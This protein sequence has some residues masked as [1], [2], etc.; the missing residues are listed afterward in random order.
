MA[1]LL[2]AQLFNRRFIIVLG[3]TKFFDYPVS[4]LPWEICVRESRIPY[5][6][7]YI[8]LSLDFPKTN[9]TNVLPYLVNT[10]NCCPLFSCPENHS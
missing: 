9:K 4:A 3:S 1:A 6:L 10:I 7:S 2:L 5:V 8:V